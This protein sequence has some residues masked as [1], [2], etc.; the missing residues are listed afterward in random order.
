MGAVRGSSDF[1][2]DLA[3]AVGNNKWSYTNLLPYMKFLETFTGTTTQPEQRG[4]SGPLLI[5]QSPPFTTPGNY[6]TV[7]SE[8][9]GAPLL[10]DYNV[11]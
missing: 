7:M 5:S 2:N 10:P 9:T 8:V 6:P 11:S 3:Q 1:Y 4:T